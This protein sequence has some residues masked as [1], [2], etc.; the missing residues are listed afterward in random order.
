[1]AMF[2]GNSRRPEPGLQVGAAGLHAQ[3]GRCLLLAG[4]LP[5]SQVVM[6][7]PLGQHSHRLPPR[8]AD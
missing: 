8:G 4:V 5:A 1:M 3:H 2:W 6:R 7:E